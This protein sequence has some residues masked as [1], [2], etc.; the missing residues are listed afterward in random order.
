MSNQLGRSAFAVDRIVTGHDPSGAST[1]VLRDS[2]VNRLTPDSYPG[3][4]LTEL[5]SSEETPVDLGITGDRSVRPVRVEPARRGSVFRVIQIPPESGTTVDAGRTQEEF[6]LLERSSAEHS[7]QHHSMHRT[8]TLDYLVVLSGEM[9]M[10]LDDSE[11][12]LRPGTCVIQQATVHGF[13][14]R[15]DEPC[16]IAAVLLDAGLDG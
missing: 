2:G 11:V 14:N 16:V 4:V 3:L 7:A 13:V 10:L 1:V 15:S 5:W 6:G 8:Q 12:L 9:W